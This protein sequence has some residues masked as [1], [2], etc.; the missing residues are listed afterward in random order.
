MVLRRR[1]GRLAPLAVAVLVALAALVS[2]PDFYDPGNL[3]N[4]ARQAAFLG[5]VALG[6]LLVVV[7]RGLDL[8]VGAVITATLLLIVEL[9]GTSGDSLPGAIVAIVAMAIGVGVLN[10]VLVVMRRVPAIL[11]TLAT[12]TLVQGVGLWLTEGQSR[13]RVPEAIKPLGTG[14]VGPVPVPVIIATVVAIVVGVVLHR[15]VLGRAMYAVGSNPEASYLSGIARRRVAA[16][17]FVA[18]AILAMVTGLMLS[19]FVGFYDRSLGVGYDLDSI[20]AVVLGGA[21]LAGG[22]GTVAGT[23]AAVVGLAAL[24]NLLVIAG[25]DESVQLVGKALVLFAAVLSASWLSS[26]RFEDPSRM[27]RMLEPVAAPPERKG[28]RT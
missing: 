17:A 6:Q 24:D 16:F 28:L 1:I 18:C 13:G 4:V 14:N 11:A 26:S 15:G 8:S 22:S 3:R 25:V 5:V 27:F 9:A 19:G 10:A 23:I 7:V 12:Y 20:A 2:Q 21:T